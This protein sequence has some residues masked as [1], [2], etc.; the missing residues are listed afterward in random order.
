M[1]I[2]I[3]TYDGS[4]QIVH[5]SILKKDGYYWMAY[6][7]YPYNNRKFE[8]P[9]LVVSKDGINWKRPGGLTNPIV[10]PP[11]EGHY[12]DPYITFHIVYNYYFAWHSALKTTHK[13]SILYRM[14][15]LDGIKWSK[16][17]VVFDRLNQFI[18]SPC[19]IGE[20]MWYV[21]MDAYTR[22]IRA[23][24]NWMPIQLQPNPW[25][26]EVRFHKDRYIMLYNTESFK[27]LYAE[28]F[29]GLSWAVRS[30]PLLDPS[31]KA[32]F[33][34]EDKFKVWY[35]HRKEGTAKWVAKYETFESPIRLS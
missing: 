13:H 23:F 34:V 5:P 9:S 24:K 31:Y 27:I 11:E 21:V 14:N 22:K 10:K 18:M 20:D 17:E 3:P 19:V 32:S 4:G 8:N 7:P 1:I 35:S 15:S 30:E 12:C 33:L 29:D 26:L 25:H 16:P 28:S 2:N 6:T